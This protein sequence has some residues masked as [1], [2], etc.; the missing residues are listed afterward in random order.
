MVKKHH[1]IEETRNNYCEFLVTYGVDLQ[2]CSFTRKM[3]T[4]KSLEDKF[5]FVNGLEMNQ[6]VKSVPIRAPIF[7]QH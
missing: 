3:H 6:L 4:L 5:C 2:S 1:K 7:K